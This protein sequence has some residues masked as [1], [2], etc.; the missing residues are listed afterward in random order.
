MKIR[1]CVATYGILEKMVNSLSPEL[2][3]ANVEL[4]HAN[5]VLNDLSAEAKR[6]EA[7]GRV[8]AFVASGGNA[9]TLEHV[10]TSIPIV[11]IRPNGYDIIGVL[12]DASLHTDRVGC[13]FFETSDPELTHALHMLKDLT[14]LSVTICT[15]STRRQLED[16]IRDLADQGIRDV[17]GGSLALQVAA[18][19]G[20]Y[21]HYIVTEAGLTE[22]IRTAADLVESR[23]QEAMQSRQ[24][25]S[26]LNFISEGVIAT[27]QDDVITLCNPSA[28]KIF[29]IRSADTVGKKVYD[30]LT[31]TRLNIVRQTGI[32]ELD[33]IQ[34]ERNTKV[35]TNRVPMVADGKVI[36]ALATF[37]NVYEVEQA[38]A[39]IRHK[40]YARGL[41][42]KHRFEDIIGD[43]AAMRKAVDAAREY[44]R[45]DATLLIVGDS[46]TGKE[47][48]AQSI[49]NASARSGKPFVAVNCAAMTQ[50]LLESEL[51][52]YEEGAFTGA[53]RGGKRGVF[54]LADSGTVFL[55]EIAEISPETQAHLLRVIEQREVMRV[56]SEKIRP[57]DIRILS[58]TN[59]DLWQLVQR[60][61][62]RKDLYYRLNILSLK[63]PPLSQRPEDVPVIFLH[64]LRRL[65]PHID[66]NTLRDLSGLPELRKY[67]WPG[68][69]RE[70]RNIAER[71]SVLSRTNLHY[72]QIILESLSPDAGTGGVEP[73]GE[74]TSPAEPLDAEEILAAIQ[75]C[76][77]NKTQA[78]RMLGIGR[79]TL[80]R[81]MK[82]LEM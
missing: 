11:Q 18:E 76:G 22:A 17:I 43:S 16:I 25:S 62:F 66:D 36:G 80:W 21:G 9:A 48:F 39:Q 8:D 5:L 13:I 55:D 31:N 27:N 61:E 34:D 3:P 64:Y 63:I 42:A 26:V 24:L 46:G 35:L 41:V 6:L 1:I 4:I 15:Y 57:I 28:E 32:K 7:E 77:G 74:E 54:E 58:A 10:I 20:L 37:R 38:E 79:S 29:G 30:V 45:S 73:N 71:F 40:L 14:N 51:F 44:A 47:L 70:L 53:R 2:I 50:Q 33:Q 12:R 23:Y 78:A 59:Q 81:R 65:C 68:N 72:R 52:G 82:E 75:A 49:H 19:Y 69:T 56:G 67:S 60:G